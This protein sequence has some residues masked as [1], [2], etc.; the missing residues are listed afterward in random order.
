MRRPRSAT[1]V[2][3]A[4]AAV[5]FPALAAADVA[6]F[7]N[8]VIPLV[9][10]A[11][12]VAALEIES[13]F[14]GFQ[15]AVDRDRT[16]GQPAYDYSVHLM[17]D[18]DR[19]R[20]FHGGRYRDRKPDGTLID[21]DHSFGYYTARGDAVTGSTADWQ[22]MWPPLFPGQELPSPLYL[23]GQY[24]GQ[25]GQW[26]SRNTLEPEVVKVRG[27]Y[28]MYSQ[29]EIRPGERVDTGQTATDVADRIQLHTSTNA[30]DWTRF[31]D[32]TTLGVVKYIDRPEATKLTHQE[33]IYDNSDPDEPWTMYVGVIRDG[34]F[35]G[36]VRMKSNDPAFFNWCH[37]EPVRGFA[38]LGNQTGYIAD[39]GGAP[40]YTRI[41]HTV[42]PVGGGRRVP[43][44]QV[45]R[46]GLNWT[47]GAALPAP[48]AGSDDDGLNRSTFF[49]G[50]STV[51]GQGP[52]EQVGGRRFKVIYGA[53]T[54]N[55]AVAGTPGG[56]IF[57]SE[58]GVG[59]LYVTLRLTDESADVAVPD[60][61]FEQVDANGFR[62][63]PSSPDWDFNPGSGVTRENVAFAADLA[64]SD[65]E[66][67]AFLQ[68][69]TEFAQTLG[70]F[71]VGGRYRLE[72]EAAG[73]DTNDA[74]GG[75]GLLQVLLGDAAGGNA[76]ELIGL[77][78]IPA[79]DGFLTYAAE[80]DAVF[81]TGRLRFLH[82]TGVPGADLSTLIDNVR[83]Y[84][85]PPAGT[86]IP[87]PGAATLLATA[88]LL[89]RRRQPHLR[90]RRAAHAQD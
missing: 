41:T 8:D 60:G 20:L 37:R 69:T 36:H 75:T 7:Q 5:T 10:D 81:A 27:K 17:R 56:D 6:T 35:T 47:F 70:G 71:E 83:I 31:S 19:Y 77:T 66:Q 32:S 62:Y 78:A 88:A 82:E 2:L 23:Q 59:E 49:L 54:A 9:G 38:E 76:Q 65:G 26:F 63:E 45:S 85:A 86:A 51:D 53:S 21:G 13:R 87:E 57:S 61:G 79:G 67:L 25:P 55:S 18:G 22:G 80:F 16:G 28:Y 14:F 73:R 42:D 12:G 11:G 89:L 3:F 39:A 84:A 34:T 1:S 33:V 30:S 58:I 64:A 50:M 24:A 68:G 15:S 72:F 52:L 29:V 40:L 44:L 43:T 74:A 46:D 90:Q 4:A 48:L